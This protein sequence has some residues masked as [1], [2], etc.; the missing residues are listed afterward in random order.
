[1]FKKTNEHNIMDA[2]LTAILHIHVEL[3]K[4]IHLFDLRILH[5][6][7]LFFIYQIFYTKKT[8]RHNLNLCI[9]TFFHNYYTK[10][11]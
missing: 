8:F 7:L 5:I 11:I 10:K 6:F 9:T 3:N 1:M 2:I 4:K